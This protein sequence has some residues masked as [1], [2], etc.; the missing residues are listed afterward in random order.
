MTCF[1]VSI[2]FLHLSSHQA[3][4]QS[5]EKNH[6]QLVH[7]R[8]LY[9]NGIPKK[10]KVCA[11]RPQSSIHYYCGY[12]AAFCG[13]L[14]IKVSAREEWFVAWPFWCNYSMGRFD[15]P[16]NL[17]IMRQFHR[18]ISFLNILRLLSPSCVLRS[19][20]H[21]SKQSDNKQSLFTLDVSPN[22][23]PLKWA[24]SFKTHFEENL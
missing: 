13:A 6:N 22:C 20:L 9:Q 4:I 5:V 15:R 24:E 8:F 3:I 23:I 7:M 17:G 11:V 19:A 14:F 21:V 2:I 16:T 18:K 10:G 12:N 1:F